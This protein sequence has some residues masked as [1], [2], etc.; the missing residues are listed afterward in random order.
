MLPARPVTR[1]RSPIR[2]TRRRR[3][4]EGVSWWWSG[5]FVIAMIALGWR[6]FSGGGSADALNVR[7]FDA[8]TGKTLPGAVVQAG[9]V[10]LATNNEG[11]ASLAMPRADTVI[12]IAMTGYSPIYGTFAHG[13][14]GSQ[15]VSLRPLSAGP[16]DASQTA[17]GADGAGQTAQ[18]LPTATVQADQA[19]VPPTQTAV[20]ATATKTASTAITTNGAVS[21]IVTDTQGNVLKGALIRAGTTVTHTAKNG[22]FSLQAAPTSGKIVVSQSG[23]KD[24]TIDAGQNLSVKLELR[25]IKAAY[26][27]GTM[28]G[29]DATINRFIDLIDRTELNAVVIDIKE[30]S[31][32]YGTKVKF[33]SDAGVV[34]KTYDPAAVVKKFH[35]HGIYVI[36]RE[37]VF[38]DPLVAAFYPDLAVKSTSGGLWKGSAGDAWVNPFNKGLWQPNIDLALEAAG[39]GFDEIQFD[40][41]RFPSDGDLK[42]ADFAPDYSE[43]ARVG[44]I[45]DFLKMAHD[46]LEPAG[47]KLAVDVFGIVAVYP[48]D[49]GIGQRLVDVAPVVDYLC[50][51]VY[52]SHFDPTSIDVGG[53]PNDHPYDTVSI[54]LTLLAKRIPG[55]ELKIR[56][57]LQDFSLPGMSAYG[58]KQVDA[59]IKAAEE[60]GSGWLLWNE[61]GDFTQDALKQDAGPNS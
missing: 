41:I 36:A 30:N 1:T 20:A 42:T 54:A 11:V 29:D 15:S 14:S 16:G 26:L 3:R 7:V 25:S 43:D 49:Q 2:I 23:Y 9:A 6:M 34:D 38:K 57:W 39:F 4:W 51:M 8:S 48:D 44:A 17:P 52:P 61:G 13:L 56:P 58:A 46:Q 10:S 12:S 53:E 40:Y 18:T 47:A 21:G 37:V 5:L 28:A 31:I 22:S 45:V 33:F 27:N 19:S 35:D 32:F 59:Q 24:Q 55:Q 60:S 50:P